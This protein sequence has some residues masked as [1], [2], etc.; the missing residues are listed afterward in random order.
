MFGVGWTLYD[1]GAGRGRSYALMHDAQATSHTRQDQAAAVALE[2]R[3]AWLD[4][5]ETLRRVDVTAKA[6]A[7]AEENLRV[8][9]SRFE[10]GVAI[11]TEVL[12]A[13]TLR[14]R[15][16]SNYYNAA[17]DAVMANFRLQRA[18]GAL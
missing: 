3:R 1:A 12:D 2:V 7:Q 17:Y 15:S 4:V 13:E 18:V 10:R 14:T 9:R 5:Q 16:Y 6:I 8:A 11:K